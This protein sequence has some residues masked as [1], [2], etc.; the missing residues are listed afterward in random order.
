MQPP[1]AY[2]E[3]TRRFYA[4]QGYEKPY[5]WAHHESIPFTRPKKPLSQSTLALITTAMP[6]TAAWQVRQ[7]HS[8]S[9]AELPEALH[10]AELAWDKDATHTND[11]GSY[12]PLK[13]LHEFV[14]DERLGALVERYHCVPTDYSQ[15][16]TLDI[17]APKILMACQEDEVDVALLIPL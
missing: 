1:V 8:G 17:D 11:L 15:R 14:A 9:S 13:A 12:F 16:H 10:T 2:M 6:L 5:S 3:R 4:A 7:V